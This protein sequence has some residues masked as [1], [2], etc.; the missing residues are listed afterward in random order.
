MRIVYKK[1]ICELMDDLIADALNKSLKKID[2][3]E[4]TKDEYYL[5]Q[6][7]P[8]YDF[9]VPLTPMYPLYS[10]MIYPKK[11]INSYKGYPIKVK[12]TI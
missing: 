11:E 1:N 2:Y 5:L 3:I 7:H 6:S 4:L 8:R 10:W 12:T 9:E